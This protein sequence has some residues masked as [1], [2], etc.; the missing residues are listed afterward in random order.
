MVYDDGYFSKEQL[1]EV[2]DEWNSMLK[3][4]DT[5]NTGIQIVGIY[6]EKG[7]ILEL[8]IADNYGYEQTVKQKIDLRKASTERNLKEKYADTIIDEIMG[9]YERD[10]DYEIEK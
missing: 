2:M 4:K 6:L 9:A 10:N 3:E 7:N 1:L 8:D 5:K